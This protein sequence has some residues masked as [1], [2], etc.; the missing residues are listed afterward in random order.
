VREGILASRILQ[1]GHHRR[2]CDPR[3][4][5]GYCTG[6]AHRLRSAP[7]PSTL[8]PRGGLRN[9]RQNTALRTLLESVG[10]ACI[11]RLRPSR[12]SRAFYPRRPCRRAAAA[13]PS[14]ELSEVA[15]SALRRRETIA[16]REVTEAL[17]LSPPR[18][19]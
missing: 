9:T 13:V 18:A 8:L 12:L 19:G 17:T 10:G 4:N 15:V 14:I 2:V 11:D 3:P 1:R 5:G 6:P 7:G 16:R